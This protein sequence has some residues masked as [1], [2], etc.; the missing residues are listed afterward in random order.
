MSSSEGDLGR[1]SQ[2]QTVAVREVPTR[3]AVVQAL[4][5]VR[6]YVGRVPDL[7]PYV[8]AF[9]ALESSCLLTVTVHDSR[10]LVSAL[11]AIADR[12]LEIEDVDVQRQ[13]RAR[14]G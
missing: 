9:R 12:G 4:V 7:W 13:I 1:R 3:G 5:Q 2:G 8:T 11:I 10:E 6:G 14:G